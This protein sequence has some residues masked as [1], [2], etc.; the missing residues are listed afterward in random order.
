MLC[1][2]WEPGGWPGSLDID[3]DEREFEHEGKPHCFAF[4]CEAWAGGSGDP[5]IAGE[6]CSDG[7]ADGGDFVFG[8]DCFDV[9]S[10]VEGEPL[11]DIG[12]G[13]DWIAC[14]DE[15]CFGFL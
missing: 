5:N 15:W 11:E 10:L 14:V 9:E 2:G 3:D 13:G 4:E 12:G 1:F 6:A 8:L 7:A